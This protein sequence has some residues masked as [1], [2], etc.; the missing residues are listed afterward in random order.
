MR[1]LPHHH[2][3]IV[4]NGNQRWN[5]SYRV[6]AMQL[7]LAMFGAF[8]TC[9]CTIFCKYISIS[10]IIPLF[11]PLV[12]AGYRNGG[13]KYRFRLYCVKKKKKHT[14]WEYPLNCNCILHFR[15]IF[16]SLF[17]YV[18]PVRHSVIFPWIMFGPIRQHR[19]P[20][21][22]SYDTVV[23]RY[24]RHDIMRVLNVFYMYTDLK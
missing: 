2:D 4:A 23:Q 3:A 10:L 7:A 18:I 24:L 11:F 22:V 21:N 20:N 1:H 15:C 17:N 13:G 14:K 8:R 12:R 6:S 19:V 5:F 16:G 9:V